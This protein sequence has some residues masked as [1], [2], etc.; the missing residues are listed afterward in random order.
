MRINAWAAQ[1]VDTAQMAIYLSKQLGHSSVEETYYYYHYVRQVN[2]VIRQKDKIS[3]KVI[4]DII[5]R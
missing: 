4:P 2:E 1:D 3:S 5:P